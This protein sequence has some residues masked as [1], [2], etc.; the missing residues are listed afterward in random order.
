M[1]YGNEPKHSHPQQ[2]KM[3]QFPQHNFCFRNFNRT[4]ICKLSLGGFKKQ[5]NSILVVK[6]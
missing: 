5:R 3:L 4:K 2:T 1:N 6:T